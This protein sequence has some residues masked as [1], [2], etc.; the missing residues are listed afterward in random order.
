MHNLI[1]DFCPSD[2]RFAHELVSSSYPASFRFEVTLDTLAFGYILPTT[3]RIRD[4]NPLETCAARRTRKE[5]CEI[6]LLFYLRER[7]TGIEPA[8]FS[9][10]RRHSTTL[11]LAHVWQ[12]PRT[13]IEPVTRGFSVLCSTDW[14]IWAKKAGDGNRTHV[15]SLEGWHSTIE[16][17]PHIT[18][19]IFK[20][21]MVYYNMDSFLSTNFWKNLKSNSQRC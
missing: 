7:E 16:L 13:G 12:M 18:F 9:L 2:Q 4:F 20:A 17:H 1:W 11:P 21:R 19:K 3:G 5:A 14:A 10:A 15:F 8:T 6:R